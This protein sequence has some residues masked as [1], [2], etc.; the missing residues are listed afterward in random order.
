MFELNAGTVYSFRKFRNNID[1]Y[2]L[3]LIRVFM[4]FLGFFIWFILKQ[5]SIPLQTKPIVN[6]VIGS[7]LE[8][9]ITIVFAYQALKYIVSHF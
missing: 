2:L 9:F 1:S 7:F 5:E 8:T 3:S 6:M 4:L